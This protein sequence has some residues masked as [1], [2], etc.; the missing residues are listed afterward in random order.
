[1][2]IIRVAD[3]ITLAIALDTR[4]VATPPKQ[5]AKR[6]IPYQGQVSCGC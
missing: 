2:K 3:T 1:M 4:G 6:L 5:V